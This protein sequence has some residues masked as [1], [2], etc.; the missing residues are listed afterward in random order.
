MSQPMVID[1]AAIAS[2]YEYGFIAIV[3]VIVLLL[4]MREWHL[5]RSLED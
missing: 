4:A 3:A 1:V 5:R 2:L